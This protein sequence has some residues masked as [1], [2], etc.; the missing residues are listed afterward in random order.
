MIFTVGEDEPNGGMEEGLE[1]RQSGDKE[2]F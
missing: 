1:R 2:E